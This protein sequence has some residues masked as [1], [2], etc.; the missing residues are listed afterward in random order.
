MKNILFL[1][2]LL[3]IGLCSCGRRELS[4]TNSNG[5]ERFAKK[6][7]GVFILQVISEPSG[8]EISIDGAYLGITPLTNFYKTLCPPF[9]NAC[10]GVV[11]EA[12]Y[13]GKTMSKKVRLINKGRNSLNEIVVR[14]KFEKPLTE[15]TTANEVKPPSTDWSN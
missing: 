15:N 10:R 4:Y 5:E 2:C 1:L 7:K 3:G 11:V 14:F 6:K 12:E 13:K 9:V 8:A